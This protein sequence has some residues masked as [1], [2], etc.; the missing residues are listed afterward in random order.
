M[1]RDRAAAR[2][3]VQRC[4]TGAVFAD[5]QS[6]ECEANLSQQ[7]IAFLPAVGAFAGRRAVDGVGA[8]VFGDEAMAA[9]AADLGALALAL[10]PSQKA[11]GQVV[12]AGELAGVN[13]NHVL[14]S[15]LGSLPTGAAKTSPP[16][17]RSATR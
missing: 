17:R 11:P 14:S 6:A 15:S 12:V 16:P 13:V 3:G 4:A 5:L 1:G 8:L 2:G 7:L 10:F 9:A